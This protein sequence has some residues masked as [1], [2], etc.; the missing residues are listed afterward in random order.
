MRFLFLS[1]IAMDTRCPLFRVEYSWK[2][3]NSSFCKVSDHTHTDS[4]C[5]PQ[6]V[7]ANNKDNELNEVFFSHASISFELS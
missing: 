7:L 5:I 6:K 1:L 4:S 3:G 2:P